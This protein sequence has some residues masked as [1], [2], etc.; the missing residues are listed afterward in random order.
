MGG[1]SILI[2]SHRDLSDE[3]SDGGFGPMMVPT[4]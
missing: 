3:A 1:G 4:E 2:I